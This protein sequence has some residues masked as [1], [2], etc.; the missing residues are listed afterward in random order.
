MSI[1][2]SSASF[3]T[4]LRAKLIT[5]LLGLSAA[6]YLDFNLVLGGGLA[7]IPIVIISL[8]ALLIFRPTQV[9]TNKCF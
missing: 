4:I 8:I 3:R 5:Y 9:D 7:E 2:F 1:L 6:F